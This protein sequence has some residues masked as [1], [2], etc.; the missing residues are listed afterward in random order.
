MSDFG[1]CVFGVRVGERLDVE[2]PAAGM[3]GQGVAFWRACVWVSGLTG[4]GCG[5]ADAAGRAFVG[6]VGENPKR[7]L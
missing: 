7:R 5:F 3:K 6:I 4:L 1:R 2:S